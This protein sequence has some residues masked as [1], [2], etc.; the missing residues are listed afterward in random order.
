MDADDLFSGSPTRESAAGQ[1]DLLCA[2]GS[3]MVEAFW[4]LELVWGCMGCDAH[5][6]T[7]TLPVCPSPGLLAF[8]RCWSLAGWWPWRTRERG[9]HPAVLTRLS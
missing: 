2:E 3:E 6:V 1:H 7:A 9:E 8:A 4:M 5:V